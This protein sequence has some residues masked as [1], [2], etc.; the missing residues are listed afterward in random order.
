MNLKMV[1]I[2]V[3][4]IAAPFFCRCNTTAIGVTYQVDFSGTWSSATHPG[5]FPGGSSHFTRLVGATHND[6]VT[7]WEV[8]GMAT[9]GLERV[10]EVG[11]TATFLDE[12]QAAIDT[13]TAATSINGPSL[14]GLP[15]S[16]ATVISVD[17]SHPLVSLASMVAP[18]PDWFVGASALPLRENGA[19]LGRVEVDLFAYD[20]GTEEGLGFSLSNPPTVPQQ[21]ISLVTDGPLAGLPALATLTFT[22]QPNGLG[23]DFNLDGRVDGEDKD[24]WIRGFGNFS[25]GSAT[26]LDGDANADGFVNGE[27]LLLWQRHYG[28]TLSSNATAL[29]VPEPTSWVLALVAFISYWP[30]RGR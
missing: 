12:V 11:G 30:S 18:S 21:P 2:C 24:H 15:T 27:D 5:A 26:V 16:G 9:E 10:A 3:F 8:G 22:A 7:F 13:G 29:T 4:T 28:E 19:W 17:E 6:S 1:G 14:F 25:D 20:A 23:G